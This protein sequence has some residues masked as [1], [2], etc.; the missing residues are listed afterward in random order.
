[1]GV[2]KRVAESADVELLTT[3][4]EKFVANDIAFRAAHSSAMM[5]F[6][7]DHVRL[8]DGS[9]DRAF[10]ED[11]AQAFG[12]GLPFLRK[13]LVRAPLG[14][15]TPAW[16]PTENFRASDHLIFH[17]AELSLRADDLEVLTGRP[18]PDLAA[19]APMWQFVVV[20][21]DDGR[22]G[23]VIRFHHVLGDGVFNLAALDSM[24]RE[25]PGDLATEPNQRFGARRTLGPRPRGWLHV[26]A[27]AGAGWYLRQG[28]PRAAWKEYWRK[29][30]VKRLRRTGGRVLRPVK[31]RVIKRRDMM[32]QHVPARS[33]RFA[34]LGLQEVSARAAE[35]GCSLNDLIVASTLVALE[36]ESKHENIALLVPIS[37]REA[38]DGG[39]RNHISMV[40]VAVPRGLTLGEV[41]G[42]VRTQ[43]KDAAASRAA[44]TQPPD[45]IGYATHVP[46]APGGRR[47][48]GRV[49]VEWFIAWPIGDPRDPVACLMSL[50]GEELTVTLTVHDRI[51]I[52]RAM[53]ALIATIGV[54]QVA[55]A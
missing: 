39:V 20:G 8:S 35:L 47:F 9:I 30:F 34:V 54:G 13:N 14:L 49:P 46:W 42:L 19:N 2:V 28:S 11:F 38:S 15:T 1:M 27:V 18:M 5:V 6:S 41:T 33:S 22:V 17:D 51:D 44:M 36:A 37:R 4:D 32:S 16:V 31:N 48:V 3:L 55:A 53:D 24:L 26:A 21:L 52:D 10:F 23:L 7:G 40:R 12:G 29:P 45:W 43:V 50:H 25:E